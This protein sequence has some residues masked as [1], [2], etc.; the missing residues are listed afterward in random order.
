MLL[1]THQMSLHTVFSD[2]ISAG[3]GP[4]TVNDFLSRLHKHE[5]EFYTMT[6]HSRQLLGSAQDGGARDVKG[7]EC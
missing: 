3:S 4:D 7:A 1:N 5:M 6:D 2:D